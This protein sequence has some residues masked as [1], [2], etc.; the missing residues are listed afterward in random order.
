MRPNIHSGR[1][2]D[3]IH[4]R[5]KNLPLVQTLGG[6]FVMSAGMPNVVMIDPGGAA[7]DVRLPAEARGLWFIIINTANAAEAL[8]VTDDGDTGTVVTIAQ[9]QIA[10]VHCDGT[11]WWAG[12]MGSTIA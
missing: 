6:D 12:L 9:N 4:L 1:A 3:Y 5:S 11:T 2:E 10:M 7:R 8:T